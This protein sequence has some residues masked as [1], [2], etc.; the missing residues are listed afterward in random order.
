VRIAVA[1]LPRDCHA[2]PVDCSS[3]GCC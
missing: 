3:C 1:V 2:Y